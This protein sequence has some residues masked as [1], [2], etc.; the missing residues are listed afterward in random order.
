MGRNIQFWKTWPE[1]FVRTEGEVWRGGWR[2]SV[3]QQNPGTNLGKRA[4]GGLV[5]LQCPA[6][7]VCLG[8]VCI[9]T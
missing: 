1:R 5:V 8:C 3:T 7:D 6:L 4:Y 9:C 2:K